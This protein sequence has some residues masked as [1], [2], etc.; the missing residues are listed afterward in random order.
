MQTHLVDSTEVPRYFYG[1]FQHTVLHQ[2]DSH[3]C[4]NE[5][6][7]LPSV[8]SLSCV[9]LFV[10]PWTAAH[11]ASLFITNSPSLLK[12]TSIESN[13]ALHHD[14]NEITSFKY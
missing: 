5:T 8:Q 11:Q 9:L 13:F 12:L 3:K 2:L 14:R 6:P 1:V 7:P 10:T 4:K